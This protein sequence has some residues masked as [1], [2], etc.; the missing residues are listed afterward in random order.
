MP[1]MDPDLPSPD[2]PASGDPPSPD[3]GIRVTPDVPTTAVEPAAGPGRRLPVVPFS[4]ALVAVLAGSALFLSGYTLGRQTATD[5]GTPASASGAFQP[6]WDT[7]HTIEDRYAGGDVDQT[8]LIQGAIRG[9]IGSLDD[10]FSSYLTSDEYRQS[11]QGISG[12]FEGIGAEI[13]AQAPDGTQGCTPLGRACRLVV[14]RPIDG[15]PAEK[16]GLSSGDVVLSVDGT[17]LDGLTVDTARDKIRGP[18][19]TV[20]RLT[21][22]RGDGAPISVSITRDIVLSREVDS[23]VLAGGSVGYIR[24]A[25]FSDAAAD[26]VVQALRD[27]LS[28]GRTR[29]ILDLRGNP[30]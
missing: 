12:Q 15:S 2:R 20:V 4:I 5:P 26:Q 3:P 22:E 24:L 28:A 19:G 30:C 17:S 9:M 23:K 1:P 14:T 6:F 8:A 27:Q 11:L 29:L 25:G 10:P 18:K 7:Y 21:I 13:A 16:A